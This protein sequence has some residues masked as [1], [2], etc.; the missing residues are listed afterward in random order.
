[1]RLFSSLRGR[2]IPC[3]C[4]RTCAEAGERTLEAR[5]ARVLWR[6]LDSS[7][8]ESPL[9]GNAFTFAGRTI[10]VVKPTLAAKSPRVQQE[11][12]RIDGVDV[13]EATD[14]RM[15]TWAL[16]AN[17]RSPHW[18]DAVSFV[19]R[20]ARDS[21]LWI[22]RRLQIAD[23]V[24]PRFEIITI[25]AAGEYHVQLRTQKR[26]AQRV[27]TALGDGARRGRS[28]PRV[29][30]VR[31]WLDLVSVSLARVPS[32]NRPDGHPLAS[33]TS[34]EAG[35][36]LASAV[37]DGHRV[38]SSV[39]AQFRVTEQVTEQVARPLRAPQG[40]PARSRTQTPRP[41]QGRLPAASP[42]QRLDRNDDAKPSANSAVLG[43]SLYDTISR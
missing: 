28:A 40:E 22:A 27:P 3:A 10:T 19:D 39:R 32:W 26:A 35:Q 23:T 5:C 17:R 24:C 4:R 6:S 12:V 7:W 14:L 30:P 41:F 43:Y 16:Q 2:E 20:A 9:A 36:G 11:R 29:S 31:C 33:A 1:M 38:G 37:A 42:R 34:G 18:F 13:G 8:M 21:S 25:D 15:S